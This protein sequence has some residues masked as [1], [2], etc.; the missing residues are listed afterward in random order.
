MVKGILSL[1]FSSVLFGLLYYYPA[2]LEPMDSQTIFYWRIL[3]SLPAIGVLITLNRSW[4]LVAHL[5]KRIKEN[6]LLI[7]GLFA[8]A[9]LLGVEMLLFVWAPINGHAV[10]TSLG[11][12]ILPLALAF[13]G[14]VVYKDKLSKLQVLAIFVACLGVIIEIY[15]TGKFS[16]DTA[17]VFIGYPLYFV[18]RK[19]IKTDNIAGFFIDILLLAVV[20]FFLM[21]S[22][23]KTPFAIYAD[24]PSFIALVPLLGVITA[25]A[26]GTYF[27]A[28]AR[29]PMV[30]FGL[31][32]YLEPIFFVVISLVL[33]KEGIP[34]DQLVSYLFIFSAVFILIVDGILHSVIY[35]IRKKRGAD[36]H[37]IQDNA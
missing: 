30:L 33:L 15:H 36:H 28:V 12:F 31:L 21:L 24:H 16:W 32:G 23:E 27:V 19:S 6:P 8:T 7:V 22:H 4:Y 1:L 13:T 37:S 3:L 34:A 25:I 17:V 9:I 10:T 26:F 5:F 35:F 11:Y 29:L 14:R 18:V 2:L 20:S